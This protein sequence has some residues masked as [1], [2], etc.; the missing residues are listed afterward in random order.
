M[1]SKGPIDPQSAVDFM[2][3]TA[4]VYAKAKAERVYLQEFRKS[5]KALLMQQSGEKTAAMQERDAYAH[6]EYLGLLAALKVAV[7][8]EESAHWM[9]VSAQTRVEVWRSQNASNR[10]IDRVT[11]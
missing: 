10:N 2:V 6:P 9:L 1:S 7:E 4:P 8:A 3:K 5:K 11:A